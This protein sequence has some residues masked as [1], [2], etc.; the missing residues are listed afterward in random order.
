MGD[1]SAEAVKKHVKV[2]IAVF[3]GL[4]FLTVVTVGVSYLH[5]PLFQ[6]V[7]VALLIASVKGFLVAAFFM[8]LSAEKK[9]IYSVLLL[10]AFFF[11]FLLIVPALSR[12]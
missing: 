12:I 5:L 8:H 11:L 4:A 10:A 2:Y 3:I 9:I 1:H 7:A 6:A